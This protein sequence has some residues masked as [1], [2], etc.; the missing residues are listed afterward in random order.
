MNSNGELC[1]YR[2][3]DY[4]MTIHAN[5]VLLNLQLHKVHYMKLHQDFDKN[6]YNGGELVRL[7]IIHKFKIN[8]SN[9]PKI[10]FCFQKHRFQSIRPRVT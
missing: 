5:T 9:W 7:I 2:L 1:S 10:T 8:H 3:S 4:S 6:V